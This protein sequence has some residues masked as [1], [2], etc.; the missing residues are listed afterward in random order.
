MKVTNVN[1]I[2]VDVQTGSTDLDQHLAR[3]L[4]QRKK[5]A[6]LVANKSDATVDLLDPTDGSKRATLPTGEAP[7]EIAVS[8]DGRWIAF[9]RG[10]LPDQQDV[11]VVRV[12]DGEQRRLSRL[13]GRV[14]GVDWVPDGRSV[15][16]ASDLGGGFG[17]HLHLPLR[18]GCRSRI[19]VWRS[20]YRR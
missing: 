14:R 4:R 16:F 17:T 20:G 8:P 12:R 18:T 7:H 3:L 6:L 13:G 10:K 15:V 19:R 9:V 2:I 1:P 11:Y 5:P